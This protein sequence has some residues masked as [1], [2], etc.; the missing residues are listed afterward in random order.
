MPAGAGGGGGDDGGAD[1]PR[2]VLLAR[3]TMDAYAEEVVGE[4]EEARARGPDA[5]LRAF[6]LGKLNDAMLAKS[7][8][9]YGDA[10]V[11]LQYISGRYLP[12]HQFP[13]EE[14]G[15]ASTRVG[16]G[17][18]VAAIQ[19]W[20]RASL[21]REEIARARADA[22]AEL[23]RAVVRERQRLNAIIARLEEQLAQF[24][25]PGLAQ[26]G[27]NYPIAPIL[28]WIMDWILPR[29]CGHC[30]VVLAVGDDD[31]HNFGCMGMRCRLP[32]QA[33]PGCG[34]YFCG[35]CQY[36]VPERGQAGDQAAHAHAATCALAQEAIP[37]VGHH[38]DRMTP[39]MFAG[40]PGLSN[41]EEG[42]KSDMKH[43][44]GHLLMEYLLEWG[45]NPD[46]EERVANMPPG[47]RI[48]TD[49]PP[50]VPGNNSA[51]ISRILAVLFCPNMVGGDA[52]QGEDLALDDNSLTR[53]PTNVM[54][55]TVGDRCVIPERLSAFAAAG[56]DTQPGG[57]AVVPG[58]EPEQ[59][60]EGWVASIRRRIAASVDAGEGNERLEKLRGDIQRYA[61]N[62]R[63]ANAGK[64]NAD[65]QLALVRAE[66]QVA[67]DAGIAIGMGLAG[68]EVINLQAA[69]ELGRA[70]HVRDAATI[71]NL[72][73]LLAE[74]REQNA[75]GGAAPPPPS[76][77]RRNRVTWA[78]D[79]GGGD[80]AAN[81]G[82]GLGG[83]QRMFGDGPPRRP[84]VPIA[85]RAPALHDYVRVRRLGVWDRVGRVVG[86]G[87]GPHGRTYRVLI[88]GQEYNVRA[89]QLEL[90]ARRVRRGG[91][92]Q[93]RSLRKRKRRVKKR[94]RK[95]K[96]RHRRK[97][98]RRRTRKQC[99]A[100]RRRKRKHTKRYI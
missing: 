26:T 82:G 86:V 43:I 91:R 99:C 52:L 42:Y 74:A 6:Q 61:A 44:V 24:D 69:V 54:G 16:G 70:R 8:D 27:Q 64:V 15:P 97:H 50:W 96:R 56:H 92:R 3:N 62:L 23:E 7:I 57:D 33:Q 51:I 55:E 63:V 19:G 68:E 78:E 98:K 21:L 30:G 85:P 71:Q 67:Q 5:A 75:G 58:Q 41:T 94:R 76:R 46:E 11:A 39:G 77:P 13:I 87:R 93:Q 88:D 10:T 100:E 90:A 12:C 4:G 18:A 89:D 65:A 34:R 73:V 9:M 2:G 22:Q 80:G 79:G 20:T 83:G 45:T 84:Y 25:L 66:A 48:A 49:P 29:R 72:R 59:L 53:R 38:V 32:T 95:T 60:R 14:V 1:D 17:D 35:Y 47:L 31:P 28:W 81:M 36:P 40:P 37:G